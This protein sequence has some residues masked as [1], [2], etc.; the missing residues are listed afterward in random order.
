MRI[1]E[2]VIEGFKSY[3]VRTQITGWDSSFNAITGL[4]GSGKSNILDAIC[5]VLGLTDMS[6]LRCQNQQDLIYKRG[7]AGVTKA[8]VTIVFDNSDKNKSPAG[9][10]DQKQ[11][12]VTRQIALPNISKYLLNGHKAQQQAIHSLFQS[13]QLNINNPNFLIQ[14]GRITKVLNMRPQEILGLV[15][16]AAG[17]RM[18]EDRKEKAI[19]TMGKKEKKVEEITAL[20]DEE[21]T[22]KLDNLRAEKRSYLAYQKACTEIE[23]LTRLLKAYQWTQFNDQISSRKDSIK[24]HALLIKELADEK[25]AKEREGK[26]AEK[27][28]EIV[29]KKRDKEI[30]KGG[31]LK[32]LEAT[33]ENGEKELARFVAQVEIKQGTIIEEEKKA[34]ELEETSQQMNESL[35]QKREQV[36]QLTKIYANVKEAHTAAQTKLSSSEELLQTLMTGLA[37]SQNNNNNSGGGYLGQ[38]AAA[39]KRAADAKTEEDGAKMRLAMV[40]KELREKEAKQKQLERE[41]GEGQKVLD[42]GRKEV[43]ALRQ[44]TASTGWSQEKEDDA[45]R[46]VSAA[47]EEVKRLSEELSALKHSLTSLEFMY[48]D[49][50]PGFNRNLVKGLVASL[51]ELDPSHFDKTTALEIAAGGR[52]YNVVVQDEKVA[53]QLLNNGKLKKRVTIIPLNKIQTNPIPPAKLAKA[54]KIAPGRVNSAISLV[55]YPEEVGVAMSY[56]FGTTLICADNEAASAVAFDRDVSLY[57]VSADGTAYDPSGTLSGGAAPSGSGILVKVQKIKEVE[58]KLEQARRLA[59]GEGDDGRRAAWRNAARE[60][61]IKEHEVRLLEEQVGGS[62]AARIGAEV[63]NLKTALADLKQTVQ[64][65]KAKQKEASDECKKLEKDMNDFKNNKDSKLRELKAEIA[66]QKSEM[67]KQNATVKQHQK[68]LQTAQLELESLEKDIR[69]SAAEVKAAKA[70]VVSVHEELEHLQTELLEFQAAHEKNV[71]KL[72]K[73]RATL[74]RFDEELAALDQVIKAKVQEVADV[75]LEIQKAEHEHKNMD[76]QLANLVSQVDKLEKKY[77]WIEEEKGTFG[78]PGSPYNFNDQ[79]VDMKKM[80]EKAR[81]LE[82][83]QK[84]M[85]KKVN[86]KVVNM[87]DSVEKKEAALKKMLTT[88]LKDKTKIE[89]TI[90]E[91]ERHKRDA[92]EKCWTKVNSDFGDIFAELL[93]G[94]FAKLVPSDGKDVTQGL[95][96]KV[97]LGSVWKE[98]LTELSGGQRSLIALSLILSLL[99]VKPAPMYILDEIDSA[100]DLSHT[101]NI[102]QLFRSRFKGSQFIVVSLKEGLFTNANVLFKARFRDGTSVVEELLFWHWRERTEDM[103]FNTRQNRMQCNERG[104]PASRKRGRD[105]RYTDKWNEKYVGGELTRSQSKAAA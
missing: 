35:V 37:S 15:E 61:E 81:E 7:A 22:P 2:L 4:N 102:G 56:V 10:E 77:T 32:G 1:E 78:K 70:A 57:S 59:S 100:L 6:K 88:V 46:K 82:E 44:R 52:L 25:K 47:R 31:K 40:E 66:K 48:A 95:D 30:E 29:E 87:I 8:S 85:S 79:N 24:Q 20:L 41:G 65:A 68:E 54:Q 26:E 99:E 103:C 34:I 90:E 9:F 16:E 33:V 67:S 64:D 101:Q 23:R 84:G 53:S 27:Q 60:L 13:V 92:L 93:P 91:L 28:K 71:A 83:S 104:Q 18:F 51:L 45:A 39:Q 43:E 14:Q 94:N 105:N 42:K 63:E 62:N 21:I 38:I 50:Y 5:F 19:R 36:A 86:P 73:E 74:T 11:I 55:G 98:S 58:R 69:S 80:A 49:P 96:V 3:P 76:A 17:T 75:D 89:K 97:R 12:T 72:K